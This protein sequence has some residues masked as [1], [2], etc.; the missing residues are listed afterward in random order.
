MKKVQVG[1]TYV[2]VVE[3]N[4]DPK[5]E[6]RVKIRV[7]DVFDDL[8]LEDIPWATP[9]KDLNGNGSNIPD[10]GK[11][12][13]TVFDQGDVYKPEFIFS[14][15]YNLNLE[16][17]LKSL[18]DSDYI[19]MKS[20]I[21][22]HKT[23]IYVNDSEGL[24]IDHKYN[25]INIKENGVNINLKDNNMMVN[26]G[27]ETADQQMLLGNN[28]LDWFDEFV[29]TL[30]GTAF[31]A[32]GSP[33]IPAPALIRSLLKYKSLKNTTLLSRH[34]N[35]VDNDKVSTVKSDKRE[36][37]AQLGDGW[38]ST[39]SENTMTT[40]TSEKNEPQDGTKPEYDDKYVAPSTEIPG[41]PD[42]KTSSTVVP[43]VPDTSTPQSNKKVEDL[44]R[45][46]NS[47]SYKI[48][49]ENEVLNIV[50][51]R[52]KETKPTNLFDDELHVFFKNT[53]GNW[54]LM[55]YSITTVP[56]YKPGTE[57]LPEN[58]AILRLGQ[59]VDQLKI[60]YHKEDEKHKCL[61]FDKCAIHR[62]DDIT[63][64]NYEST[65]ELGNFSINIHR[66]SDISTADYV[67]NYS[68]GS[69]VFKNLNQYNQFIKLCENQEK[70]AN[71]LLFTYTLCSKKEF[72]EF[73]PLINPDG[74]KN[75]ERKSLDDKV[76][77][78]S[79]VSAEIPKGSAAELAA[80]VPP[81]KV[82]T[83]VDKL[84]ELEFKSEPGKPSIS[85]FQNKGGTS[86]SSPVFDESVDLTSKI[87]SFGEGLTKVNIDNIVYSNPGRVKNIKEVVDKIVFPKL[88]KELITH[89]LYLISKGKLKKSDYFNLKQDGSIK[90]EKG[91]IVWR[92]SVINK[93]Y[94]NP[95]S[96]HELKESD[97]K[98][99]LA[100]Y[101][102]IFDIPTKKIIPTRPSPNNSWVIENESSSKVIFF[103]E[104]KFIP[105][106]NQ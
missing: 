95:Y 89:I 38:T 74:T 91:L 22:D 53:K 32:G 72:E 27:D 55:E 106:E 25:N 34:V 40:V 61:K 98:I 83:I 33:T 69:Q 43:P 58:V 16:N 99:L 29:D 70:N 10:K 18:S 81:A 6:G 60:G 90:S 9:W 44:I 75:T 36:E 11:V 97:F 7:M 30:M 47:K 64:Y 28:W 35:V 93:D 65:T 82:K 50:A 37:S 84:K 8:K 87:I 5:K 46:L 88:R 63:K 3:D 1:K 94:P 77:E 12:V 56:G 71:K 67:L 62:N 105:F 21:F 15:H 102:N 100:K 79:N 45:F 51:L 54:D 76:K 49:E 66:S 73:I 86:S 57:N 24:K 17:K 39:K 48:F 23:Q 26:I 96:L 20:L 103:V 42:T 19:S 14:D 2:G 13:I 101:T 4:Q 41:T 92:T 78:E 52:K 85:T 104:V 59:Y 80:K 68:E 31:L